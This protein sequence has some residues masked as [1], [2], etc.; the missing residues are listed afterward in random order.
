MS[1]ELR[2][3]S[4]AM[5]RGRYFPDLWSSPLVGVAGVLLLRHLVRF[6]RPV[7]LP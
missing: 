4:L 5:T 3:V 6:T 1:E 2:S 7:R